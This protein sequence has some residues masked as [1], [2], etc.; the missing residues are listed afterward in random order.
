MAIS[1]IQ[2]ASLA[3][4]VPGYANLP[5]GSVLQVVQTSI[6]TNVYTTSTSFVATGLIASLTPKFST[7]K[8]LV[9]LNGGFPTYNA[10]VLV[11]SQIFRQIA[12]GSYGGIGGLE[13]MS[14]QGVAYGVPHSLSWLD[15]PATT[16]TVNYQ[17]YF[18]GSDATGAYFNYTPGIP[19]L[20]LMEIAG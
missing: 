10:G 4:G 17:P 15:S 18:K 1:T 3:S 9:T 16:S 13:Q 19:T 6:S 14:I 5:T 11:I 7:S 8:I 20:T 2:N 12:S